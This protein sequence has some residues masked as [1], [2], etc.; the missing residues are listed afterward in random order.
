MKNI[1]HELYFGRVSR[2]ERRVNRTAEEMA[3][4]NKI[5]AEKK[6]FSQVFS[7]EN[8]KRLNELEKLY[9]QFR[10]FED[11]RTFNYAFRL[12]AMLMCAVF[13]EED[14]EYDEEF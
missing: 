9:G 7:D 11:M 14:E 8:Y 12:G 2:W 13:S 5:Q 10:D 1:L 6:H 4:E 3:V